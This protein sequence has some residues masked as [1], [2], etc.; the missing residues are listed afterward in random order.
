VPGKTPPPAERRS[1]TAAP[2][3]DEKQRSDPS[4][5]DVLPSHNNVYLITSELIE[6]A[7]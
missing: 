5:D 6:C 7:A 2:S 3:V 1:C 4:A